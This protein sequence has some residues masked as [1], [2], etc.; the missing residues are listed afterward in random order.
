MDKD[1][2]K[3][4]SICREMSQM[5]DQ[6]LV[7]I[8]GIAVYIHG[9]NSRSQATL[10]ETTH[11]GDFYIS[12]ADMADLR[13]LEEVVPNR[14]L[15]KSQII[16]SGFEFDV[17]TERQSSLIVPYDEVI[18]HSKVFDSVRVASLGHLFALKMEA[19]RDRKDSAKGA[20]DARDLIRLAALAQETGIDPD[21]ICPYMSDDHLDLFDR[22]RKSSEATAL[23]H[24]NAVKAKELRS[25]LAAL[26]DAIESRARTDR[27][28]RPP[29]RG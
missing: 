25:R 20:K 28:P 22:L 24:G 14:R 8:G 27:K 15:S 21:L 3:L 4:L 7:F 18:A 10:A 9:I 12:L 13:D 2:K 17:Y 29:Q 5:F 1:F 19:F 23:A 11:D 26:L 6:G 16:K